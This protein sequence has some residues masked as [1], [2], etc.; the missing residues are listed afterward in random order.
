MRGSTHRNAAL[1]S[2][3]KF[4]LEFGADV[5]I[6]DFNALTTHYCALIGHWEHLELLLP[7]VSHNWIRR[8]SGESVQSRADYYFRDYIPSEV[9]KLLEQLKKWGPRHENPAGY[10]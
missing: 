5:N 10:Y 2:M 4:M 7:L 1:T 6:A 8:V 9:N 3:I